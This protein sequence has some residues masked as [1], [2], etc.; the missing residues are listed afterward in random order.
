MT[1]TSGNKFN[2]TPGKYEFD[3]EVH[4]P[5]V[6]PSSFLGRCGEIRYEVVLT[7]DRPWRFDNVFRQPFTVICPLDLNIHTK[8]RQPVDKAVKTRFTKVLC[9]GDGGEM[10]LTA[11]MPHS[12]FAPGQ[13]IPIDV[14]I[15]NFSSTECSELKLMLVRT[16][17][18]NSSTPHCRR[19]YDSVTLVDHR[20]GPI[21]KFREKSL[22]CCLRIPSVPPTSFNTCKI[23]G[24]S[25]FVDF[26]LKTKGLHSNMNMRLPVVI[27]TVPLF[28]GGQL[29][30]K[31]NCQPSSSHSTSNGI[32]SIPAPPSYEEATRFDVDCNNDL[33]ENQ[34]LEPAPYVP[35][36]PVYYEFDDMILC[37]K[38][39]TSHHPFEETKQRY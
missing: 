28:Y 20:F 35:K 36:Y 13:H 11:H 8:Y 16:V 29:K 27:G 18:Y 37:R 14:V 22:S 34:H 23:I 21:G 17:E 1:V 9:C 19:K 26:H 10:I 24:L 33:D 5:Y 30:P 4:L 32:Y 7:I 31:I 15:R 25:Y 2:L 39:C 6:L 12:G 38:I 3:F